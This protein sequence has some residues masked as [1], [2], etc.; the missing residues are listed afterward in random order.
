[1]LITA[2]SSLVRWCS[3]HAWVVA[4]AAAILTAASG[5]FTPRSTSP[6]TPTST[7][8]WLR[9]SAGVSARRRSRLRFPARFR[10][11]WWWSMRRPRSLPPKQRRCWRPGSPRTPSC[12]WRCGRWT[13]IRSLPRTDCCFS[14]PTSLT[15]T[16]RG[17]GQAGPIIGALAGDPSLRG[18]TRGLSF[19]L[20]G[21]QAGRRQARRPGAAAVDGG[22][23]GG[24]GA[25]GA[26]GELLL[27]CAAERADAAGQGPAPHDR[28]A[29]GAGFHGARAGPRRDRGDPD[30][31]VRSQSGQGL[32]R[33]RAAH[34]PGGD[35]RRRIRHPSGG[36]AG[37]RHRHH[38]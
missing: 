37:E 31:G 23:Y 3:H 8:S 34:R 35:G 30:R 38:R 10:R 16:T 14:P 22:G 1:M 11:S 15:R 19:G 9:I 32:S 33:P 28:D 4:I 27:A 18:L 13:A 12:S 7:S 26:A 2:V 5:I 36:R 21:V 24:A 6:S 29:A 17:L 20:L 25:G